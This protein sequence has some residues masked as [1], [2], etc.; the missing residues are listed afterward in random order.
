MKN[1]IYMPKQSSFCIRAI[2]IVLIC[3]LLVFC[4]NINF[5]S[6]ASVNIFPG[7]TKSSLPKIKSK[8]VILVEQTSGTIIYGKNIDQ[9]NYPASTQKIM[10]G[11]LGLENI[12]MNENLTGDHDTEYA[13]GSK[14]FFLDGEVAPF[15]SILHALLIP[16]GNDAAIAIAKKVSKNVASF[17]DLMN[18]RAKSLGAY[19]TNFKNPSGLDEKGNY[20]TAYDLSLIAREALKNKEFAS[21]VK[22]TNYEM[23]KTNKQQKRYFITTNKLLFD[24]VNK[25]KVGGLER[26]I[27]Y[28]DATGVKTGH[29]SSFSLVA[30]AKRGNLS[31]L[32]VALGGTQF[33]VYEDAVNLFEYGFNNFKGETVLEKNEYAGTVKIKNGEVGSIDALLE[34]D[35]F[36]IYPNKNITNKDLKEVIVPV[37]DLTAPIKKGSYIGDIKIIYK[38]K[39]I[40]SQKLISGRDVKVSFFHKH[41]ILVIF[42]LFFALILLLILAINIIRWKN[43]RKRKYNSYT[44]KEKLSF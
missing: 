2:V 39:T 40:T 19:N 17:V 32:V 3:L 16:S 6:S 15:S 27:K 10:T 37:K 8:S 43:I 11:M 22:K 12:K 9:K 28:E 13:E 33:G 24:N 30:S 38:G 1:R 36:N 20:T 23:P 42:I 25:I 31:F 44:H 7:S 21:I 5:T 34:N 18:K 14:I 41:R 29:D 4:F 35:F 26:I